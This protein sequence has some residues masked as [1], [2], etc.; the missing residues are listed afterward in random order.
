MLLL[1]TTTTYAQLMRKDT[2]TTPTNAKHWEVGLDLKPLWEKSEP[3]NFVVRYFFKEKWALR[4]GVGFELDWSND[5]FNIEERQV[6]ATDPSLGYYELYER[7]EQKYLSLQVFLG[8]QYRQ[9]KGKL[10]CYN[11]ADLFYHRNKDFY[12]VPV[13]SNGR[14]VEP[15]VAIP[16]FAR[17]VSIDNLKNGGGIRVINGFDYRVLSNLSISAEIALLAQGY[18]YRAYTYTRDYSILG[19]ETIK[20][21][22]EEGWNYAVK[23]EPLFRVFI[24]YRF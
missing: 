1:L 15:P 5:T 9:G 10:H 21:T 2:A 3:Y 19:S 24:N 14:G 6:F 4:G 12:N 13:A 8:I 22:V 11:A 23:I 7:Q 16:D 20:N 17:I 18:K